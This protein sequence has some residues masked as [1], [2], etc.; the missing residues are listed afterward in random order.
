MLDVSLPSLF[1]LYVFSTGRRLFALQQVHKVAKD[2]GLGPLAKHVAAALAHDEKT[3]QIE[4]AWALAQHAPAK[5]GGKTKRIDVQVDRTLVAIRDAVQAQID[6]A[7]ASEKELVAE[8]EG[9]LAAFFPT[10]VVDVI[11][12][13]FPEELLAV[14]GIVHK[15]KN[16]YAALAKEIGIERLAKHLA[17]LAVDY[18]AAQEEASEGGPRFDEVRAARAAGHEKMLEVVAMILGLFPLTSKDHVAARA[19][20]LGP[21][22]KQN[23]AIR[24]YLRA[25]RAPDDVDPTTG[26][27]DPKAPPPPPSVPGNG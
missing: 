7:D 17:K 12:L 23:D 14:D 26:E 13:T 27:I 2:M 19:A 3:H 9:M 8:L 6:G 18:R 25:R 15:L 1:N 21:I 5:D 4:I 11:T 22:L 16:E 20:L 10:G 24:Q